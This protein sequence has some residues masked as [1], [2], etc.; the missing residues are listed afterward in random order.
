MLW[1]REMLMEKLT[2]TEKAGQGCRG[3]QTRVFTRSEQF[4]ILP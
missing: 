3:Q 1:D 2:A 4:R